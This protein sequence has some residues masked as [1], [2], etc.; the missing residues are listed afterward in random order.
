MLSVLTSG[1]FNQ[2]DHFIR[3]RNNIH[4]EL[5]FI[6]GARATDGIVLVGDKKITHSYGSPSYEDKIFQDIPNIVIGAAGVMGVYDKF[7][8]MVQNVVNETPRIAALP[9]AEETEKLVYNLNQ[10]YFERVRSKSLEVLVAYGK[11]KYGQLQYIGSRGVA[12]AVRKYQAIGSG[13]PYAEYFLRKLWKSEMSMKD[14][15]V[16]GTCIIKIIEEAELDES[17]GIKGKPQ[18]WYIPDEPEEVDYTKLSDPEKEVL[19]TREITGKTLD[20]IMKSANDLYT[21]IENS[22][23]W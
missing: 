8:T 18:I 9:F 17:V 7:R 12:E 19:A 21:K 1:C 23:T 5:T 11:V 16:L 13:E 2:K 6:L 3:Y 4:S 20:E 15:A 10:E 14:V 22:I